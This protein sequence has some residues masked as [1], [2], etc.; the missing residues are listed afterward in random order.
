MPGLYYILILC[1][2]NNEKDRRYMTMTTIELTA[3]YEVRKSVCELKKDFEKLF[4]NYSGR[5]NFHN[6]EASL[7][8]IICGALN[9][10]GNL[11]SK[12]LGENNDSGIPSEKAD[13]FANNF[14]RLNNAVDYLCEIWKVGKLESSENLNLLKDIRTL[15]VHSGES[16]SKIE[17]LNLDDYKDL[18]LG[19]IIGNEPKSHTYLVTKGFDYCIQVWGDRHDKSKC[20]PE[21]EV[22]YDTKK[23]NFVEVN[24]LLTANTVKNIIL[25][26][27]EEFIDRVNGVTI[28][29]KKVKTLP[30]EVKEE[31]VLR[32]NFEKLEQLI[33]K[34][35]RGGYFI[36]DGRSNWFGFG[37]EKLWEY[38]SKSSISEEVKGKIKEVISKRLD[39]F[40][41]A[42]NNENIDDKD[43][44]TLDIRN[45]FQ[46]YTPDYETKG[47]L[48]GEKLFI[49]IAP[50]FNSKGGCEF[51]GCEITDVD[52]LVKFIVDTEEALGRPLNLENTVDGVICDYFAKSVEIKIFQIK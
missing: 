35:S 8:W 31:V 39:D 10:L 13:H 46:E 25:S 52:Y 4:N 50:M 1:P 45:V 11:D 7:R 48:E 23:E 51:T 18:Q 34:K 27:I 49:N 26:K 30:K 24:I 33:R 21:N 2:N 41:E 47:Y 5:T 38:V 22:D 9:Y 19:R 32:G 42:Y 16:L 14:Y 20:R 29:S 15:I 40:W 37:L 44:P 28:E 6:T 36:E 17:S 3:D 12:F 43:I